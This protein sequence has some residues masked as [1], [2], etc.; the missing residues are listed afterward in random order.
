MSGTQHLTHVIYYL[1]ADNDNDVSAVRDIG[2]LMFSH[3][4]YGFTKEQAV[5]DSARCIFDIVMLTQRSIIFIH[6]NTRVFIKEISLSDPLLFYDRQFIEKVVSRFALIEQSTGM[7]TN[8]V[9]IISGHGS[10]WYM[11]GGKHDHSMRQIFHFDDLAAALRATR[12]KVD[13]LCLDA[14]FCSGIEVIYE[15]VGSVAYMVAPQ[16]YMYWEGICS[17]EFCRYFAEG[18]SI[19]DKVN[20]LTADFV[21]RSAGK[22]EPTCLTVI[23][24][25]GIAP[26]IDAA[27]RL[28]WKP[29]DFMVEYVS[30]SCEIWMKDCKT[31]GSDECDMLFDFYYTVRAKLPEAERSAFDESYGKCVAFHRGPYFTDKL[32]MSGINF[33]KAIIDMPAKPMYRDTYKRLRIASAKK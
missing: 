3:V 8:K 14:C 33:S 4:E 19:W 7:Q 27:L 23:N 31:C 25:D 5:V 20:K 18:G 6:F 10:G 11:H 32:K 17:M 22:S 16:E 2:K 13:V 12:A 21:R 26:M 15:L 9:L 28:D 1:I 29:A 30:D 24:V